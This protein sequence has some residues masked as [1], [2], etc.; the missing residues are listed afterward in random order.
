MDSLGQ[1]IDLMQKIGQDSNMREFLAQ[2][3]SK[4]NKQATNSAPITK[5]TLPQVL[6]FNF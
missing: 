2:T 5:D 6:L 3:A 1:Y 4:L